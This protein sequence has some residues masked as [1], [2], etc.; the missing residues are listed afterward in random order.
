MSLG[1][2]I[3]NASINSGWSNV[4]HAL[5]KLNYCTCCSTKFNVE[6]MHDSSDGFRLI[7]G[8]KFKVVYESS[9][10]IC[11]CIKPGNCFLEKQPISQR[12]STF[13]DFYISL[14]ISMSLIDFNLT[15]TMDFIPSS[16]YCLIGIVLPAVV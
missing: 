8:R 4:M 16:R 10:F 11:L 9:P 5:G 12:R 7:I 6:Y 2:E 14:D 15:D 13:L 3:L 1:F